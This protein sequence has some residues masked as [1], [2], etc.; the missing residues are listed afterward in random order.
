MLEIISFLW[1]N[2]LWQRTKTHYALPQKIE[3]LENWDQIYALLKLFFSSALILTMVL[4][5]EKCALYFI[6][7]NWNLLWIFLFKTSFYV[8]I[9]GKN[10]RDGRKTPNKQENDVFFF[11]EKYEFYGFLGIKLWNIFRSTC[12]VT[13]PRRWPL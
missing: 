12:N 3:V 8:S 11:C 5:L 13:G 7:V 4:H 10:S 2:R 1:F 6:A 9:R